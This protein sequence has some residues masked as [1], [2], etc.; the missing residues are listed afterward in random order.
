MSALLLEIIQLMTT[1]ISEYAVGLGGGLTALV[2]NIYVTVGE[3]GAMTLS[4]FGGLT[5]IFAAIGLTIGL[6][7]FVL[8]WVTS[9]GN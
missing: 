4:I 5:V 9:F 2:E 3:G 1:G 6:S 7:R 8:E